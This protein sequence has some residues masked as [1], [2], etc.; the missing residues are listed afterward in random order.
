MLS[1]RPPSQE[2]AETTAVAALAWLA[3]DP[4]ALERF[5]ATSGIAVHALRAAAAEPG[6]LAGVL[7]FLLA[8]EPLLLAFCAGRGAAPEAVSAAAALLSHDGAGGAA[9]TDRFPYPPAKNF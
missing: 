3:K 7:D 1:R 4:R 8:D 2:E 6:F 5:L 9:S